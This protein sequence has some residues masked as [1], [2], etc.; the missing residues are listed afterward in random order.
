MKVGVLA[1]SHD[2]LNTIKKALERFI[3]EGVE[4]I[5]HA[6]DYV[7]PFAMKELLKPGIRLVGVFGNNDGE[8]PGLRELCKEVHEPP[9]LFELAGRNILLTHYRE[10]VREKLIKQADVFI[11]G[12]TH[13]FEIKEGKPLYIN[14]GECGGWLFGRPSAAILNLESLEAHVVFI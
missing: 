7:A 12:H 10:K 4:C 11:Y 14:P 2:N 5:L 6:G 9:Y 3:K 13:E 8:K 1:D